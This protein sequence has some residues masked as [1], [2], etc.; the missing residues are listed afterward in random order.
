ML[1]YIFTFSSKLCTKFC[2]KF[3]YVNVIQLYRQNDLLK[4]VPILGRCSISFRVTLDLLMLWSF[5]LL[6]ICL[7][8]GS[9]YVSRALSHKETDPGFSAEQRVLPEYLKIYYEL[10]TSSETIEINTR[11]SNLLRLVHLLVLG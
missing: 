7:C 1:R 4:M 3:T 2:H 10:F 5:F 9:P 8:F 11:S 6:F